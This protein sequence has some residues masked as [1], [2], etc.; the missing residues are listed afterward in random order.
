MKGQ[1]LSRRTRI[2]IWT[3]AAGSILFSVGLMWAERMVELAERREATSGTD[4]QVDML[5]RHVRAFR[6]AAAHRN[7]RCS[8]RD[9]WSLSP[10]V[11]AIVGRR[12]L[13]K[14]FQIVKHDGPYELV[15][16][17]SGEWWIPNRDI[18]T[19]AE[20]L[21]EQQSDV[22]EESDSGVGRGDVVL[23]CGANIGIYTKHALDKGASL[24]V[25]IEMA[26]ESLEC[27]RRNM[28]KEVAGGQVIVYPKGVWNRDDE[29]QLSVGPDYA[30]TASS[31]ALDRGGQG[32]KVPLT[33]I[34]KLVA[35]LKLPA[36]DFIK[37]DIEGA[38]MEALQGAVETVRRFH[39]RM[40]I[41][42]EHRPTDPDRIPELVA[43]LW[44]SYVSACNACTN[45][46]NSIQPDVLFA[47]KR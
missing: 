22:Y 27:L 13:R 24:V 35:E 6:Y 1:I 30:S 9:A 29:L 2:L 45:V 4:F 8:L 7:T 41:S 36:V 34:D 21:W 33:T 12:Q 39:P 37:M 5:V 40:A 16:T 47:H 43:Q 42:V 23:D 46:R 10:P 11:D 26:P 20:T 18:E 31:V 3:A 14:A 19:L 25:A 44:P 38:E 28:A 17:P 32:P 15:G